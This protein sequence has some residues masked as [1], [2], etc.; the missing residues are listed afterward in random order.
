MAD[1]KLPGQ[2]MA[3]PLSPE[4]EPAREYVRMLPDMAAMSLMAKTNIATSYRGFDVGSTLM[5]HNGTLNDVMLLN[6]GNIKLAQI[7]PK[8]CAEMFALDEMDALNESLRFYGSMDEVGI[9]KPVGLVTVGTS[10]KGQIF[11]VTDKRTPT[12]HMCPA[13]VE[14]YDA[15]PLVDDNLLNATLPDNL[16]YVEVHS[17]GEYKGNTALS[18]LVRMVNFGRW[19]YQTGTYDAL[20]EEVD[21]EALP[22]VLS[23]I[24]KT[25]IMSAQNSLMLPFPD[26]D[27]DGGG[28]GQRHLAL[29]A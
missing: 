23:G 15:H 17:L 14:Y 6:Y 12:L 8:H 10:D 24:A 11:D 19:D 2:F 25:A 29:A 22:E 4:L 18:G 21:S 20:R 5:V 28:S 3:G 1:V 9:Y 27:G 7:L 13:C 26:P 16:R